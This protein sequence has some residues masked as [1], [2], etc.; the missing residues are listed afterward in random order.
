[1]TKKEKKDHT[2]ESKKTKIKIDKYK[3][4]KHT[5]RH[6]HIDISTHRNIH[7]TQE[8]KESKRR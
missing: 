1:M 2:Y 3:K 5:Y 7:H 8:K 4:K 6:T